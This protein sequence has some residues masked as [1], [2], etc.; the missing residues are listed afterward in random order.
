MLFSS[1]SDLYSYQL[2][3]G[4][5]ELATSRNG[6]NDQVPTRTI[7]DP[8][9]GTDTPNMGQTRLVASSSRTDLTEAPSVDPERK[10]TNNRPSYVELPKRPNFSGDDINTP[11]SYSSGDTSFMSSPRS[12]PFDP[13]LRVLVVDD[14]PLT[15]KL[16]KRMLTR[17]GCTV[18][19]AENGAVALELIHGIGITP[20]S[21]IDASPSAQSTLSST[22]SQ[23]SSPHDERTREDP[24][25]ELIFLDNQMPVMSGLDL[26]TRLRQ[27][28]STDFVVGVTGWYIDTDSLENIKLTICLGNALLSDQEEYVEAGVDQYAFF[29]YLDQHVK[30]L[31][32]RLIALSQNLFS[33]ET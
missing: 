16:M 29:T 3:G 8:S 33:K 14:D 32:D 13:P 15:R 31:T 9:T 26:I 12:E 18:S 22:P 21:E 2:L 6:E 17:L 19:T 7:G 27:A 23:E 10:A 5:V 30:L 28:G 20:S 24:R 25:Y 1:D 4:L 11:L